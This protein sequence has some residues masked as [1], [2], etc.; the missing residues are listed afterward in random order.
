M[1]T[2]EKLY[3]RWLF[4]LW[5]GDFSVAE[6]ILAPAAVGHWPALDVHGPRE[7]VAQVRQ[8]HEM[9]DDISTSLDVGPVLGDGM[10][11]AQWTLHG[12]YKGGIPGA[13]APPGTRVALKGQDIFRVENGLLAEYWVVSDAMGMMTALGAL[14][15]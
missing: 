2:N 9:F 14:G 11:A 5:Q 13:T 15:G 7:F 12:S 6:E 4:D 8:S 3:R 10:I 1:D